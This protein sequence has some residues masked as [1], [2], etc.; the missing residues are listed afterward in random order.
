VA[1][2]SPEFLLLY[3]EKNERMTEKHL[4]APVA[5]HGKDIEIAKTKV[6]WNY[7]GIN[8]YSTSLSHILLR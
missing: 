1:T 6:R 4:S 2:V 5:T 7:S 8:L 3:P